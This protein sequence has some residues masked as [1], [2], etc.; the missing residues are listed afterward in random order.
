VASLELCHP[1]AATDGV[2]PFSKKLATFLVIA[3][4]YK[5]MT[6]YLFSCRLVTIP[7]LPSSDIMLSSVLCKFSR[8]FCFI[9]VSPPWMVSPGAVRPPSDATD[10][11]KCYPE[12]FELFCMRMHY[13][14]IGLKRY[15]TFT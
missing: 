3:N 6:F 4:R 11:N 8:N 2:T 12:S 9:R 5:V 13:L 10:F 1:G 7:Q 15:F 14:T